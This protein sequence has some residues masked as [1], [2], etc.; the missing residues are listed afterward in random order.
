[1]FQSFGPLGL[2]MLKMSPPGPY[3][4]HVGPWAKK[5]S[6][7]APQGHISAM[8]PLG[9]EM[10]SRHGRRLEAPPNLSI[11][12]AEGA[13]WQREALPAAEGGAKRRPD[14]PTDRE[15]LR[16]D[17]VT[18]TLQAA[19]PTR[20]ARPGNVVIGSTALARSADQINSQSSEI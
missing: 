19:T 7:S 6:N 16:A 13:L 15:A 11:W 3:C 9:L 12:G 8:W 17:L 14:R 4:S 10:L 1:M 20:I 18:N 2:E 5:C